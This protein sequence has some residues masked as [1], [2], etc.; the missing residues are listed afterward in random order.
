MLNRVAVR[1]PWTVGERSGPLVLMRR[2]AVGPVDLALVLGGH[3]ARV[4]R[5]GKTGWIPSTGME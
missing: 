3:S 5:I 1:S 4:V 2:G